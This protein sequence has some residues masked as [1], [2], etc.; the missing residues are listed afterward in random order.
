MH[1]LFAVQ[2]PPIAKWNNFFLLFSSRIVFSRNCVAWRV[3]YN[4]ASASSGF[5]LMVFDVCAV[6]W[7]V[8][9]EKNN[10]IWFLFVS[11][12]A[13]LRQVWPT[14]GRRRKKGYNK[15]YFCFSLSLGFTHLHPPL[16]LHSLPRVW[17]PIE[18][19]IIYFSCVPMGRVLTD[20]CHQLWSTEYPFV[21][22]AIVWWKWLSVSF[23]AQT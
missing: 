10:L 8:N 12:S 9:E 13:P 23:S 22:Y 2:A 21:V 18:T 1:T 19:V 6:V 15:H 14:V 3:M 4:T 5:V 7:C 17:F 20:C 11:I 16:A